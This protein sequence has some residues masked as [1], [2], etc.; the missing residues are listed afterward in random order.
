MNAKIRKPTPGLNRFRLVIEL[1]DRWTGV[2]DRIDRTKL[3]YTA[4]MIRDEMKRDG[5]LDGLVVTTLVV[6]KLPRIQAAK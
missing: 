3:E 4:D 6:C 2:R 5:L 1:E